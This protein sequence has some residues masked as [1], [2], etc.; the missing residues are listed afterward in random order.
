MLPCLLFL[1]FA[2]F[3]TGLVAARGL[4]LE[5]ALREA[6]RLVRT[7][8][9]LRPGET[10]QARFEAALER[11]LN[12]LVPADRV[13]YRTTVSPDFAGLGNPPPPEFGPRGE[14]GRRF[15]PG[16]AGSAVLITAT[17]RQKLRTPMLGG[18]LGLPAADGAV[19]I[20]AG[21]VFRNEPYAAGAG[22]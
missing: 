19:L 18:L 7:G 9:V 3:E 6:A 10:P 5:N 11:A 12:G 13:A 2:L 15:D 20:S 14:P 16:A 21:A 1:L 4:V 22:P 17:Y 8:G